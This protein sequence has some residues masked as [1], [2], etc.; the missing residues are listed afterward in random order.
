[1]KLD[2]YDFCTPELQEK[3]LPN[4]MKYKEVEDKKMVSF[5]PCAF[6][7]KMAEIVAISFLHFLWFLTSSR[8]SGEVLA[9]A[10]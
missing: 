1:M 8:G 7:K 5:P 2:M 4:R 6:K 10:V 3:L 9:T